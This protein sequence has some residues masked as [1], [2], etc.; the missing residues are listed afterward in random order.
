MITK[1]AVMVLNLHTK[2]EMIIPCHRHCDA[3]YILKMFNMRRD[4]DYVELAQG[5]LDE[6]DKFYNRVDAW[7]EAYKYRQL[8][9]IDPSCHELYSEDVW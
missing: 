3:F 9:M 8:K 4:I 1:A 6:N 5:F 2:K 7:H